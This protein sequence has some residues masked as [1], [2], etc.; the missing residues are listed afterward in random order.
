[1]PPECPLPDT[2]AGDSV[3]SDNEAGCHL[4][5]ARLRV[6]VADQLAAAVSRYG[7]ALKPK[8]SGKG[9]TG[10]P[11]EQ[12]RSPLEELIKD[13]AVALMFKAGEVVPVGESTLSAL[14]SRP[15]YA[16]NVKNALV[17]FV[18][19]KAPGKGA[20]PRKYKDEHDRKQWDKLKSLPRRLP[21]AS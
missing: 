15:D 21:T 18:E 16:V 19:V 6:S 5:E 1:M 8:L 7:T 20:D 3:H 9:A 4:R 12:L 13:A 14:Q 11:E 2:A 10:A 17:G